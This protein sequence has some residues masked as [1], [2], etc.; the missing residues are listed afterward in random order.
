MMLPKGSV[1]QPTRA[2][3]REFQLLGTRNNFSNFMRGATRPR[4]RGRVGAGT[5]RGLPKGL[6]PVF[7]VSVSVSVAV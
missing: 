1:S 4:N 7:W 3:A 2:N 5:Y 6:Q